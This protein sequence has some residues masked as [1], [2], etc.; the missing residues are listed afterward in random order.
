ME[1]LTIILASS[2]ISTILS[3]YVSKYLQNDSYKKEYYKEIIKKRLEAYESIERQI[4]ILTNVVL[5]DDDNKYYHL[6]FSE[7][8]G[9]HF[10]H[11]TDLMIAMYKSIWID[12]DTLKSL[13]KLNT[14]FLEIN[15]KTHDKSPK[16]IEEIAKDYYERLKEC[17][18]EL[19]SSVMRDIYDLHDMK[20][21][22]KNTKRCM[23]K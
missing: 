18:N 16:E 7:S 15:Q 19:E 5:S 4:G 3:S 2:V 13:K 23:K 8:E 11:Q 20:K 10:Q 1:I 9:G 12:A 6:M 14:I 21:L 17:R 22:Y